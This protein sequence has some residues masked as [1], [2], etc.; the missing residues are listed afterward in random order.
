MNNAAIIA[1][2]AL[3]IG[4]MLLLRD[5]PKAA[6][7]YTFASEPRRRICPPK[8]YYARS[9]RRASDGVDS[10]EGIWERVEREPETNGSI[11]TAFRRG[12]PDE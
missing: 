1:V 9:E 5:A 12:S 2:A 3:S 8:P 6:G 10:I 7:T 4:A 11:T